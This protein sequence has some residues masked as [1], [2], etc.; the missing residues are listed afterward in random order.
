M[1]RI[2]ILI[3]ITLSIISSGALS[4]DDFQAIISENTLNAVLSEFMQSGKVTDPDI[5]FMSDRFEFNAVGHMFIFSASIKF[6]GTIRT[7]ENGDIDV[8]IYNY[9][10]SG[11]KKSKETAVDKINT[12]VETINEAVEGKDLKISAS[13]IP[14]QDYAGIMR[15]N[16]NQFRVLPAIP[17]LR[18]KNVLLSD[19]NVTIASSKDLIT[20]NGAEVQAYLGENLI[21]ELIAMFTRPTG[22]AI[23]SIDDILLDLSEDKAEIE[24]RYTEDNNSC[25]WVRLDIG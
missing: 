12:V 11:K 16:M 17:D 5:Q 6:T 10:Q 3:C 7:R 22:R 18:I 1:K 19:N 21:N 23:T 8:I 14:S 4:T 2:I 15:L 25:S 20:S 24:I 13:Y 9:Y